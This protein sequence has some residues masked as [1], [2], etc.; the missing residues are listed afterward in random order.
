MRNRVVRSF[1]TLGCVAWLGMASTTQ[2]DSTLFGVTGDGGTPSE[3][4]HLV[5]RTDASLTLVA[6]LGSLSRSVYDGWS[7]ARKLV[8]WINAYNAVTLQAVLERLPRSRGAQRAF[9]VVKA[10][11]FWKK[12]YVVAK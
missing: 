5:S 4:L 7:G 10:K 9:S 11:G 3:A 12:K 2:A 6:A 1:V 8:F